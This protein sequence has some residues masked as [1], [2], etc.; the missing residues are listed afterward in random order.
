MIER[1]SDVAVGGWLTPGVAGIGLASFS[2]TLATKYRPRSSPTW[3]ARWA[4][5]RRWWTGGR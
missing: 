5:R 3:C 1:D 2:L 4:P